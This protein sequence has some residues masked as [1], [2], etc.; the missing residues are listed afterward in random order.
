MTLLRLSHFKMLPS[1]LFHNGNFV[2]FIRFQKPKLSTMRKLLLLIAFFVV[3]HSG[4]A[5]D[6]TYIYGKLSSFQADTVSIK[7]WE[8]FPVHT[9]YFDDKDENGIRISIHVK[10]DSTFRFTTDLITAKYTTVIFSMKGSYGT[11]LLVSPG[12]SLGIKVFGPIEEP[13]FSFSGRGAGRNTFL[14]S[15]DEGLDPVDIF[16]DF[17]TDIDESVL[18]KKVINSLTIREKYFDEKLKDGSIDSVFHETLK[19]MDHYAVLHILY[20][21]IQVNPSLSDDF[22][23]AVYD[24]IARIDLNDLDAMSGIHYPNLIRIYPEVLARINQ[25][26]FPSDMLS[27]I[28][29]GQELYSGAVETYYLNWIVSDFLSKAETR[30]QKLIILDYAW[31]HIED[32]RTRNMM[33][34]QKADIQRKV[35]KDNEIWLFGFW[36]VLAILFVIFWLSV[37]FTIRQFKKTRINTDSFNPL[38]IPYLLLMVICLGP[39][40]DLIF[41][42]PISEIWPQVTGVLT[43]IYLSLHS[44]IISDYFFERRFFRYVLVT[45]LS[46]AVYVVAISFTLRLFGDWTASEWAG[47][48]RKWGVIVWVATSVITLV[49]TMLA[50]CVEAKKDFRYLMAQV[51]S[52]LEGVVHFVIM[53][54]LF[55]YL[56]SRLDEMKGVRDMIWFLTAAGVFYTEAFWTA[57]RFRH[58]NR[59][60]LHGILS[61]GIL[62]FGLLIFLLND[63][64]YN[65]VSLKSQGMAIPFGTFI[66]P[67]G[68]TVFLFILSSSLG[69]LYAFIRKNYFRQINLNLNLF[70]KK[71]AE[72]QQL[73][74]QVNP[75]F[76]F[77]SL[78]LV[79]AQALKENSEQTAESIAKLSNLMRYLIEDMDQ[80]TIPVS[81]EIGYIRDYIRLQRVRS[82]V[83]P[84]IRFEVELT[85][86]QEQM[87]IA[88]MLMIPFVENAFKHGMNPNKKSRLDIRIG[89]E[90]GTFIFEIRNPFDPELERFEK[91]KG[92]GIGI[93]NVRKRLEYHY[94]NRHKL[95][96]EDTETYYKVKL[97]VNLDA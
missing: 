83:D 12:D 92:F 1:H 95:V 15:Q 59:K 58:R 70:R 79:Y 56:A 61:G 22:V 40:M 50:N 75:H 43:V 26:D 5:Q 55:F 14:Q 6:T 71:E 36:G 60:F 94:P 87:H 23:T 81:K 39:L 64:W 24:S 35:D 97:S 28:K 73:R 9:D 25:E 84:E 72:L 85:G 48:I 65:Y 67:P 30:K 18:R 32:F 13:G 31:E 33:M 51:V 44:R 10:A 93:P 89:M 82:S 78:N 63:A 80:E 17:P 45:I 77:N 19:R 2:S 38:I 42:N 90:N 66:L 11:S 34:L 8:Y 49:T 53:G 96:I 52:H 37:K 16:A 20:Q 69:T 74:S 88:P 7:T 86:E 54:A 57:P 21:N 29:T 41:R 91:E 47:L 68:I 46:G 27:Q 76:L 4:R 62:L 3:S